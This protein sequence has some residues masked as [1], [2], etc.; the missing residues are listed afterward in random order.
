MAGTKKRKIALLGFDREGRST[1]DVIKS[2]PAFQ[3]DEIWILD[4]K[5][6]VQ[7]PEGVHAALGAGYL[8][9]LQELGPGD[10]IFRTPGMRYHAPEL[11]R[12][13]EKGVTVTSAT[14]L[15]F[16]RCRCPIVGVT[17]TKGKG[18]TS[19]LIYEILKAGGQKVFLAGNIG[20][21]ALDVL[22]LLDN[23]SIVI[24]ELSSFQLVDLHKSPHVG[25]ALMVT[26]EHLDWHPDE[27]DYAA[28]KSNIVRWQTPGD[29]AVIAEDYPKSRA[30][31]DVTQGSVFMFSR[32]RAVARGAWAEDGFFWFSEGAPDKGGE[33]GVG[34]GPKEKI[35]PTSALGIP[36]EHNWEN[37]CAAIAAGKIMGVPTD[38]IAAAIAN[39]R[40]LEHRLELVAETAG[41]IRWYNDSYSTTPDA[42]IVAV[43]AFSAPKIMILGG[44]PK[45][46]DFAALG[47]AI[48][49]SKSIRAVIGIGAEWP[50]IK[51]Q[52]VVHENKNESV[53]F[54]ENCKTMSDII[55]AADDIAEPGDVVVLSPAC[56]SFDM[57]KNYSERGAQFKG[58]I[59]RLKK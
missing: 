18:T 22:P 27:D 36:G 20:T 46:S 30:Y 26:S 25:V 48:A 16:D 52:I 58:E 55:R 2:D 15:F 6:G 14:K 39:F 50:R 7:T 9:A 24:L 43:E 12:A 34:I 11:A 49:H 19:S 10:I 1:F 45:G 3:D 21:P 5:E 29:F 37:A 53:R 40:G 47:R 51:E 17:G 8:S 56:A 28:A 59:G 23:H 54:I 31:A 41:G 32:H 4:K 35:C 13:R 44:S 38:A 42:A 33:R 57:F